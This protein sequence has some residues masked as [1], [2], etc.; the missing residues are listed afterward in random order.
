M[1]LAARPFVSTSQGSFPKIMSDN[2]YLLVTTT[3]GQTARGRQ[4]SHTGGLV[5]P[6]YR[7]TAKLIEIVCSVRAL[8]L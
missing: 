6:R 7:F 3:K 2:D 1:V 5:K 8:K 4:G